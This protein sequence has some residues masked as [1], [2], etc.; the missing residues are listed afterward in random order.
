M[1]IIVSMGMIRRFQS[2]RYMICR[3][4]PWRFEEVH[5]QDWK[6][7]YALDEARLLAGFGQ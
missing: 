2:S 5:D 3:N 4:A 6:W 7:R 1:Q